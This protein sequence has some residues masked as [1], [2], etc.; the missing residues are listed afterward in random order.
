LSCKIT[1]R[2]ASHQKIHH[3]FIATNL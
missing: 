3:H 2:V 1:T